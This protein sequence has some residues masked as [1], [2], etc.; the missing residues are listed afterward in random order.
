MSSKTQQVTRVA[1]LPVVLGV[2]S[3]VVDTK[4]EMLVFNVVGVAEGSPVW[5]GVPMVD[6]GTVGGVEVDVEIG[7]VVDEESPIVVPLVGMVFKEVGVPGETVV[8]AGVGAS[9][10]RGEE[11][12]MPPVVVTNGSVVLDGTLVVRGVLRRVVPS[13]G[14]EVDAIMGT[15]PIEVEVSVLVVVGIGVWGEVCV[16]VVVIMVDVGTG[17]S[18]AVGVGGDVTVVDVVGTG[19]GV[20]V[21]VDAGG[22]DS[23]PVDVGVEDTVAVGVA[24]SVVEDVEVGVPVM[25]VV[26]TEEVGVGVSLVVEIGVGICVV[27]DVGVEG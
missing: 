3:G 8:V 14:E 18:V 16:V 21:V 15:V 9:E 4:D 13:E 6:V 17:V 20:W 25:V 1:V 10:L 22:G 11:G 19:V 12:V 23:V 2:E 5:V 27:L 7:L 26:V 24:V